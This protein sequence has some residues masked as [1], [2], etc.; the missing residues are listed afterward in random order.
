MQVASVLRRAS[1]VLCM[2]QT[3]SSTDPNDFLA[4]REFSCVDAYQACFRKGGI[5]RGTTYFFFFVLLCFFFIF[6]FISLFL[7]S[8]ISNFISLVICFLLD[9]IVKQRNFTFF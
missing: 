6:L 2:I 8:N 4:P 3:Q 5:L 7:F 9:A 1:H